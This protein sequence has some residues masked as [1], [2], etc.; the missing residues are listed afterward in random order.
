M[1]A[2]T[3]WLSPRPPPPGPQ[4]RRRTQ[5]S[6]VRSMAPAR[7]RVRQQLF[8][9]PIALLFPIS[10]CR[11]RAP[12]VKQRHE[13]LR[14]GQHR[15]DVYSTDSRIRLF[16]VSRS[17]F[18]C[19]PRHHLA[20]PLPG[21]PRVSGRVGPSLLARSA[22]LQFDK[23]SVSL[24]H[25]SLSLEV[26]ALHELAPVGSRCAG[27]VVVQLRLAA[28]QDADGVTSRL[29]SAFRPGRDR[30]RPARAARSV[31]VPVTRRGDNRSTG[32]MRAVPQAAP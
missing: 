1:P 20:A 19:W 27:T 29:M 15:L 26:S 10:S 32:W 17:R 12:A 11:S 25:H 24:C 23:S 16:I 2:P 28:L 22:V 31:V 3:S 5:N 13:R 21:G 8:D 18:V 14:T 4:H 30:A 6:N 7:C 9:V